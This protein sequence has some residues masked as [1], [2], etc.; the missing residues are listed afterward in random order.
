[1]QHAKLNIFNAAQ[2]VDENRF[3]YDKAIEFI[4]YSYIRISNR[5]K[6]NK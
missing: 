5:W 3:F 4:A 1:M 2:A 6:L